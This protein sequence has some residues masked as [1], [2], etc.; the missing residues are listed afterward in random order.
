MRRSASMS[1]KHLDVARCL[2]GIRAKTMS[3]IL[4]DVVLR[5]WT[6]T[7][8]YTWFNKEAIWE[9]EKLKHCSSSL[10]HGNLKDQ[11]SCVTLF[12]EMDCQDAISESKTPKTARTTSC[13]QALTLP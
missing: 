6:M 11:M 9:A 7:R 3:A 8:K 2:T 1:F 10:Y 13:N 4:E 12:L 5:P